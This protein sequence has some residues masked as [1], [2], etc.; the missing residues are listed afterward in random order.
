[1]HETPS[2]VKPHSMLKRTLIGLMDLIFGL[3]Y[4]SIT[5]PLF[6]QVLNNPHDWLS[7]TFGEFFDG[8]KL[9]F[10]LYIFSLFYIPIRILLRDELWRIIFKEDEIKPS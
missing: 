7:I 8:N 6:G 1:M 3:T 5:M 10:N 9:W 2:I 4:I